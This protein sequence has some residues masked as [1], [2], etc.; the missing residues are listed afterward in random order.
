MLIANV[1]CVKPRF[2]TMRKVTRRADPGTELVQLGVPAQPVD[3]TVIGKSG[4]AGNIYAEDGSVAGCCACCLVKREDTSPVAVT[5]EVPINA[6][7]D[8]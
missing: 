2:K 8:K 3:A 4:P 6:L 7:L 1:R 5:G